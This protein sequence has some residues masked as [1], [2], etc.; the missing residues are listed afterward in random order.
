MKLPSI[1]I[2]EDHRDFRQAVRHFLELNHVKANMIEASSG[3]EGV[4]L[5][6]KGKPKVVIMDFGLSGINGLEAAQQIKK[7]DPQCS[8]IMLTM[9]EP[10]EVFQ[11]PRNRI[12]KAF[13]GKCD[14]Y[15]KLVPAVN[16]ALYN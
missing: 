1:L 11:T 15:E 16:K 9:F 13:I 7:H 5:A 4:V 14:L 8:I 10:E 6:N 3:E 12:V 2:V